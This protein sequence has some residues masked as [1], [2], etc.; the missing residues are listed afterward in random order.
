VYRANP[1]ANRVNLFTAEPF[2]VH[3]GVVQ[4]N[5]KIAGMLLF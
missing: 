5:F 1:Q 3:A 4:L 2:M